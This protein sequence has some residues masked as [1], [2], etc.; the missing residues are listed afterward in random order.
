MP[1]TDSGARDKV[2]WS[3]PL[4]VSHNYSLSQ[5]FLI[6]ESNGVPARR[7]GWK[8]QGVRMK[9][10]KSSRRSDRVIGNEEARVEMKSF[11]EALDSYPECFARNPGVSFEQHR[12]GFMP[13]G[14]NGAGR[15]QRH[16][17]DARKN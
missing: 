5:V 13:V 11:L 17:C 2:V 7:D 12:I 9:R 4:K 10:N 1:F 8:I 6:G 3:P 16:G 14:R 15:T